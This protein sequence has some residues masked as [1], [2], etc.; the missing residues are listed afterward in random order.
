MRAQTQHICQ[1][2]VQQQIE[3]LIYLFVYLFIYLFII[4]AWRRYEWQQLTPI[5]FNNDK[6]NKSRQKTAVNVAADFN[7]L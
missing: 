5:E 4:Y 3:F 7:F 1:G 6:M 2:Q